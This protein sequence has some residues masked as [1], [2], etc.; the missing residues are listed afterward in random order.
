MKKARTYRIKRLIDGR[1][2]GKEG[3]YVAIPERGYKDKKI[4]V[5]NGDKMMVV[6]DWLK[7]DAYRR[8]P[9]H[10]GRGTYT[11]G[12]FKFKEIPQVFIDWARQ[13]YDKMHSGGLSK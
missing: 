9:D 11:L 2:I 5:R 1:V 8:F 12:Y 3:L 6:D 4:V 7:A 13:N 10:W